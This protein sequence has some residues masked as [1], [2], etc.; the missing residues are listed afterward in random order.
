MQIRVFVS[1]WMASTWTYWPSENTIYA[2]D[3]WS[4][5]V[6][7]SVYDSDLT[8]RLSNCL[9]CRAAT[10]RPK[11]PS[12]DTSQIGGGNLLLTIYFITDGGPPPSEDPR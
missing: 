12:V 1:E 6:R 2:G 8:E 4:T 9:V 5:A 3:V 11:L 7:R 10:H